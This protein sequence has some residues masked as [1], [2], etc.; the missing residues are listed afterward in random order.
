MLTGVLV[1]KGKYLTFENFSKD[2]KEGRPL[3]SFSNWASLSHAAC[4]SCPS[5]LVKCFWI[6][7]AEW[8][9]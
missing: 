5:W 3:P 1:E 9:T 8:F 4:T 6:R 7:S 2:K